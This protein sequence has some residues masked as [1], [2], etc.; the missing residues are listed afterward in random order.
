[1]IAILQALLE[2]PDKGTCLQL[3]K[4]L[5]SMVKSVATTQVQQS[6]AFFRLIHWLDSERLI[7]PRI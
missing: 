1:M 4:H 5:L 3:V 6:S 7:W 2:E